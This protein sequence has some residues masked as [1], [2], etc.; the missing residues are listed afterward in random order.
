[1]TEAAFSQSGIADG[2]PLK[3]HSREQ[4]HVL[5]SNMSWIE[6]QAS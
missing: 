3:N 1:M 5:I 2:R 4:E 6:A